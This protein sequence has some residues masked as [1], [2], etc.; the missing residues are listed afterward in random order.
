MA[1][2]REAAR[3]TEA[4]RRAQLQLGAR[5][6][7]QMR[8]AWRLLDFTDLDASMPSWLRVAMPII[9][10]QHAT[11]ST[12]AANYYATFRSL[13][14]GIGTP[15][16]A[17][18]LA[19]G[20]DDAAMRVSLQVTGPSTVKRAT[21]RGKTAAQAMQLGETRSASAAMRQAL[22]G[23]RTTLIRS[24]RSDRSA[25]GFAR[26]TSGKACAFCAM[27]ASRGPVYSKDSAEFEAHDGCSCTAEP[28]FSRD[29]DWP[30]GS[31]DYA[32]LWSEATAGET[33]QLNAFRRALSGADT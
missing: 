14:L 6:V 27:L 33:D 18:S 5:T 20:L 4:H 32:Q 8:A 7:D 25:L 22:A 10:S 23:G 3:L 17:P 1:S 26:A 9:R 15:S 2:T 24:I 28:V 29:A 13:E 16:F 30:A 11:S 31:R 12:L 21:M 19:P